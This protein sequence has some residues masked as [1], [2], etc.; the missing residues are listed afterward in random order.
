MEIPFRQEAEPELLLGIV[1][2]GRAVDLERVLQLPYFGLFVP[3]LLEVA[4]DGLGAS[5]FA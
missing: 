3:F 1:D 2:R 4:G 5:R